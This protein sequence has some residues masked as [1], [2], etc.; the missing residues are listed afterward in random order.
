[1][2]LKREYVADTRAFLSVHS[3]RFLEAWSNRSVWCSP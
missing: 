1:M 3:F 2:W